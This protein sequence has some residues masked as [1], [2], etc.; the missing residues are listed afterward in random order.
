MYK[1]WVVGWVANRYVVGMNTFSF[2]V[3]SGFNFTVV[4]ECLPA[5]PF[6]KGPDFFAAP[7]FLVLPSADAAL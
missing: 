7:T 1:K 3:S 2:F 4:V 5:V 6:L